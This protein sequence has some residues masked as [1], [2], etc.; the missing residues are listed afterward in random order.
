MEEKLTIHDIARIMNISP[1]TV[2]RA[3]NNNPRI[4]KAVR[5]EVQQLAENH[6][7]RRNNLATSLR[8]GKSM[9]AGV[10]IPRITRYFFSSVI[11]GMEEILSN[12]G[13]NLMICQTME[14]HVR[15]LKNLRTL[16]DM[17]VDA[18]FISLSAGTVNTDHIR[19]LI[20]RGKRV[21][22]F[23]R[24]DESL[25]AQ[26]V[27]L[28]DYEGAYNCVKHMLDQGYKRI[29]HFAGPENLDVYEERKKGYIDALK[30]GDIPFQNIVKDTITREAGIREFRKLFKEDKKADGIFAAS[31]FSALGAVLTA[32]ELN[33][34]IPGDIGVAG[35]ANEPFT[36]FV[37]PGITTTDQQAHLM[38]EKVAQLFLE[39]PVGDYK[40]MEKISPELLIRQSTLKTNFKNE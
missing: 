1:S 28:N 18:I 11:A 4:S 19:E 6:G 17:Q 39:S 27:R 25:D 8:K 29:V 3:L 33:V 31:D 10:I 21:I 12:A 20:Q 16:V 13:Y 30:D 22:M 15:E 14:S 40:Q 34:S 2:S 37:F 7:Y 36:E 9:T 26:M 32:R 24:I 23:D 5:M 35:F 38:G